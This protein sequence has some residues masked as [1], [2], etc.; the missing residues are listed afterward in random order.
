MLCSAPCFVDG[1]QLIALRVGVMRTKW[2]ETPPPLR[3]WQGV[4]LFS[5][6]ACRTTDARPSPLSLLF[7]FLLLLFL[8]FSLLLLSSP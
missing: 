2:Y 7:L 3:R 6:R 4:D 1:Y 8:L 5:G